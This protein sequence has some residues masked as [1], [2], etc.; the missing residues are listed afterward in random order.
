VRIAVV[1]SGI[2]GIAWAASLQRQGHELVVYEREAKLGGVWAAAYPDVRLQNFGTH[3]HLADFP[4]PFEPDEHPTAAQIL[5]YLELAVERFALDVRLEHEVLALREREGGWDVEV[6][7]P[8]GSSVQAFDYVVVAVGQ[9]TQPK[10]ELAIA[11]RDRFAGEVVTER[12]VHDLDVLAGKRVAV[13]GFGKSAVDLA[14]FAVA[15]GSKVEHVFRTPRWLIP[16]YLLDR[17]HATHIVFSRFG[18]VMMSS[19]AHPTAGTRFLHERTDWFIRGFWATM[20]RVV[21]LQLRGHA[22]GLGPDARERLRLVQ[23]KHTLVSDM[24][25]AAALAPEDYYPA[26]ARGDI[27]PHRGVV[28]RF[29][30][31]GLVLEDGR[32]IAADLVVLCLGSGTPVFP[33]MPASYR[34]LLERDDDGV[35]LYR[36]ILHP[37]IPNLAF[38]GYNHGFMHVPA[39]EVAA[40]WVGALLRG[41]LLLPSVAEMEA[42]I[43]HVQAWKRANI[44]YEP[45]RACAVNTRFQQYL[46]IMLTELGLSPYRK[47]DPLSEQFVRYEASDYANLIEEYRAAW[48]ADPTPRR[49]SQLAT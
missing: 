34:E 2:S 37:R 20:T 44:N 42:A 32:E 24:R 40:L 13:V 43:E 49:P 23:P 19:W 10:A 25:S 6:R 47:P 8:G 14:A 27:R 11:E 16:E 28:E 12:D 31:R 29:G 17:V 26:V 21:G 48:A 15:R 30:E 22:R 18:S 1:G 33:F 35:Q 39:S 3:Y 45:S 46:D 36:H 7:G 5:R 38:A 4:W 41:E 9:Y